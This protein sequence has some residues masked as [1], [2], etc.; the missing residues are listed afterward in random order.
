[1]ANIRT[2]SHYPIAKSFQGLPPHLN[3]IKN[4]AAMSNLPPHLQ[5]PAAVVASNPELAAVATG[6]SDGM[7]NAGPGGA[8]PTGGSGASFGAADGSLAPNQSQFKRLPSVRHNLCGFQANVFAGA[9]TQTSTS[10]PQV[11]FKGNRLVLPSNTLAGTTISNFLVGAKP[12][13]AAS[14]VEPADMFEE[15]STGAMWDMDVCEIGQLVTFSCTVTGA[16][17]V[18]GTLVGEAL[19]GKPYPMLRSPLKRIGF[20]ANNGATI[21]AGASFLALIT[22]Q[23][24][25]KTRKIVL[26]DA[27]A[28]FFIITSLQV[29]INPQFMSGDPVPAA[30]F[31]ELAQDMWLDLDEAYIGNVISIQVTNID[32]AAHVF[33]GALSGDI[34]PRDMSSW[35]GG[36][37]Y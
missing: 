17:T 22:P 29:G 26:D 8:S 10:R 9:G 28:K 11:R 25:F 30:A 18:Y 6:V 14:S 13:Y 32:A 16:T 37:S 36:G 23:V 3:P 4:P 5:G 34:D 33:Q 35:A 21:A 12:Q 15:Q 2:H 20:Q 7:T 1:M 24:R 19:D 31:T 27:T